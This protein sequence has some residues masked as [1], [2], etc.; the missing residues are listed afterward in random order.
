[1]KILVNGEDLSLFRGVE[2]NDDLKE[3]F[4][5]DNQIKHLKKNRRKYSQLVFI[6]AL[7]VPKTVLTGYALGTSQLA[8]TAIMGTD[9]GLKAYE[10]GK[11]V[12]QA[13]C[14]LGWLT[15]GIKCVLTGTIDGLGKV[16]I[17]WVSFAL[18]IK[19][20]PDIVTWIFEV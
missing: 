12:A 7:I 6:L 18:M 16:A 9:I 17:K 20:L 3:L 13:I 4:K 5:L 19:F 8:T 2:R 14:L 11:Y 10:M 1:M 15:E